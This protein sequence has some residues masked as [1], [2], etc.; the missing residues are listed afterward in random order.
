MKDILKRILV[1]VLFSIIIY[2]CLGFISNNSKLDELEKDVIEIEN[3]HK[4]MWDSID[5]ISEGYTTIWV[6]MYGED[7]WYEKPEDKEK[8]HQEIENMKGE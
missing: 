2:I 4:V 7:S 1:I 3:E 5:G 6:Q 8:V